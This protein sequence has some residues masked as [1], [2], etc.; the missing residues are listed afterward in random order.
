MTLPLFR[1]AFELRHHPTPTPISLRSWESTLPL[2]GRVSL[3]RYHPNADGRDKQGSPLN[4]A[5]P[6]PGG[7]G[8]VR[9]RA[10][11]DKDRGGVTVPF[12]RTTFELRHLPTPT[13]ISL[14]SW[15][16]TLPLQGR[17]NLSRY[18][19]NRDGRDKQVS[20]LNS[21]SPSPGG[22]GLVRH[23]AKRDKDRGGVTV[24][25]FRTAFELRHHPTPL[26]FRFAHGN[27]PSPSRGG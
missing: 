11:R 5:S 19:P 26:P 21:A 13:P 3:S 25:L 16:S 17:V 8:S 20:A 9:H 18:H 27:R 14:R 7:G 10:K 15:E 12:F 2:Q 22:G 23:R 1:T 6:S 24:P 4:S